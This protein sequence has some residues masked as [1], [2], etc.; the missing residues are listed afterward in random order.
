MNASL[1]SNPKRTSSQIWVLFLVWLISAHER[2]LLCLSS[3]PGLLSGTTHW[4]RQ[5]S[6]K[7]VGFIVSVSQI[8]ERITSGQI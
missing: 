3:S 1:L 2:S 6:Q 5:V 4:N 8:P 7:S